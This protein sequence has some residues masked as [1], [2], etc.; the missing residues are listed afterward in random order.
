MFVNVEVQARQAFCAALTT[1][2]IAPLTTFKVTASHSTLKNSVTLVCCAQE[3]RDRT[4]K[5]I[6]EDLKEAI[7]AYN[8]YADNMLPRLKTKYYRKFSEVE[9]KPKYGALSICIC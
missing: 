5:R 8:D 6:K 1:D 9:V 2:V 3:T 7:Q 4:R